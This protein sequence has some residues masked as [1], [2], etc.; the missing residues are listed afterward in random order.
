MR[1]VQPLYTFAAVLMSLLVIGCGSGTNGQE[2]AEPAV[3]PEQAA[4]PSGEA[5]LQSAEPAAD[6]TPPPA[7]DG[8]CKT[9]TDCVLGACCHAKSCVALSQAPSE[10]GDVMCTAECVEGTMDCGKGKCVCK[11]GQC[12]VEWRQ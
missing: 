1:T 9:D 6:P 5:A 7:A 4:T 8:S 2:P 3:E 11:D 12:E 10:C